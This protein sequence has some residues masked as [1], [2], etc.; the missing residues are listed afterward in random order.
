MQACVQGAWGVL[1]AHLSEVSPD[2][3]RGLL[4]GLGNQCGVLLASG[5]VYVEAG[6]ARKNQYSHAMAATA[7]LVFVL[8][9]VMTMLGH[10]KRG[11]AFG[12]TV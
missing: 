8:A 4:P 11:V 9:I 3:L 6:L 2:S 5:I 1:P 7:A 10:E 12:E